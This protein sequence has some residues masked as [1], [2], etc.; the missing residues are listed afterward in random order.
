M[1]RVFVGRH[2]PILW[3]VRV[4]EDD[5]DNSKTSDRLV[6]MDGNDVERVL[7]VQSDFDEVQELLQQRMVRR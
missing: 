2:S 4:A 5:E 7:N 6:E 3:R 1:V